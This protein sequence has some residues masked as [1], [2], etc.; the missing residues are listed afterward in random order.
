MKEICRMALMQ[1]SPK[2]KC[3]WENRLRNLIVGVKEEE[4][5][6]L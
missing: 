2:A 1:F 6:L 5:E 4:F 3:K